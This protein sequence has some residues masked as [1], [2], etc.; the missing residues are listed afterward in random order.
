M[1]KGR[2]KPS[3]HDLTSRLPTEADLEVFLKELLGANDRSCAVLAANALNIMLEALLSTQ[4]LSV[5][6]EERKPLFYGLAGFL[7]PLSAKIR[8]CYILGLIS[9]EQAI[10]MH[11][12]R[13]IRNHFAHSLFGVS[14][15]NTEIA[16]ECAKLWDGE[17]NN[18]LLKD[19]PY[20]KAK[21]MARF[22]VFAA[23]LSLRYIELIRQQHLD[24]NL[25][26]AM[27]RYILS[28]PDSKDSNS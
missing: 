8:L 12:M 10:H 14:F 11:T 18:P 19:L 1:S 4:M 13:E 16:T 17:I 21:F 28:T 22:A 24:P 3:L 15:E 25:T 7:G 6:P 27:A 5:T 23:H 9:K 2:R 26:D 20:N